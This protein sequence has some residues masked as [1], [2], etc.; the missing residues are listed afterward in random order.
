MKQIIIV[1][2]LI[3]NLNFHFVR[4][5]DII[6]YGDSLELIMQD[7]FKGTIQWQLSNDSLVWRDVENG[8]GMTLRVVLTDDVYFRV[9]QSY[10]DCVWFSEVKFIRLDD[11]KKVYGVRIDRNNIK[12]TRLERIYNSYLKNSYSEVEGELNPHNDDFESIYPFN[13]MRICNINK[14]SYGDVKIT[15]QDEPSFSRSE[16]TF[17]EIPIFYMRRFLVDNFEYRLISQTKYDDFYPAPM[18]IEGSLVLDKVYVAV[19]ETSI[20]E[21][22]SGR[23]V[24]GKLP[25]TEMTL[26]EF[27]NLYQKKG[28]GFS[29]MDI[30][31]IMSLQHLFLIR[32]ADKNSQNIVG[33]G[34]SDLRQP[35]I[36]IQNMGPSNQ[37]VLNESAKHS[38]LFWFKN[39]SVCTLKQ[40][41]WT[42]SEY[43]K[44]IDII[45]NKPVSGQTTFVLDRILTFDNSM[46]FGSSV[47]K[48]GWTDIIKHD[49]GRTKNFTTDIGNQAC[50]IKVFG[51]ENIWGNAWE[52]VDGYYVKDLRP[53][54]CYAIQEY[55]DN[56]SYVPL[57]YINIEQKETNPW[58]ATFGFI[59]NLGIDNNQTWYA[60]PSEFGGEGIKGR[61][62]YGDFY[63]QF[64]DAKQNIY[65]VFGGGFDHF[66]RVGI[67]NIRNS[68]Y[69]TN[70]WYLYGSRM[71][72]KM[73]K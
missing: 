1:F 54:V 26:K 9:K 23:S 50:A 28:S 70:S 57:D 13:K 33:G 67:F 21:S 31:T 46:F 37:I 42:V 20:D 40:D 51:I 45:P 44:I 12:E 15:Y 17:V 35:I 47:Q 63:Y 6:S 52:F 49:T 64:K 39:Q 58:N 60:M 72:F 43:A 66:D 48:T 25:A 73:L 16:D 55:S 3:L 29:G 38:E 27:R 68:I 19:Y 22:G 41:C 36:K 71:Q 59:V 18:F 34:W 30:R 24:T 4:S 69:Q 62:C 61:N 53:Y 65:S 2:I 32:Y 5:Q 10:E 11:S 7:N 56:L 8:N 14:N